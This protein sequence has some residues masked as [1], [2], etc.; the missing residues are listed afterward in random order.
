MVESP[1]KLKRRAVFLDRDGTISEEMGY[2]N[3]LSRFIIFPYAA[4][5]I[6]RLNQAG[7]PVIVV[8]NQS[9]AARGFFPESLVG[10]IHEKM[11]A[12]LAAAGARVD[13]IYYCPHIRDNNCTCRKPIPG[14]LEQAAREHALELSNSVLV[15]DRYDDISMGQSV[16]CRSIL[17]LSGYGR[18]EYEW[19][20]KDWPR[21]PDDVVEDLTAAVELI[22]EGNRGE[23]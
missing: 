10:E 23:K 8:T 9:G 18:G 14:M 12:E 11:K 20:R 2:V 15:S 19:H 4:A 5:A 6:R 7:L 16:G 17:V 13:G 1:T 3:H 22:L 21:Q